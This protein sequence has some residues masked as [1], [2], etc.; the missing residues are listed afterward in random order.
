MITALL[1][2]LVQI[3]GGGTPDKA[4]SAYWGGSIPWVTVKD[5][6]S[7]Q[8]DDAIDSITPL[9]VASSATHVVAAG[10]LLVPTRMAVGKAAI[11]T[12]DV[13]INQDIKALL[14]GPKIDVRYLLHVLVS[15]ASELQRQATGATVK[16]ITLDVLRRLEIPLP[17]LDEQRRLA[18]VLDQANDL[19]RKRRAM[20]ERLIAAPN[21]KFQEMFGDA[22]GSN[23]RY[24]AVELNTVISPTRPITYGILKPGPDVRAG[25][26]YVRVVDIKNGTVLT[27]QLRRTSPEIAS[28]YRRSVL[29]AGDLLM[30]IRGHVGRMAFVPEE[31][32]GAN[33]TQDT[34]R[35]AIVGANS[36]FVRWALGSP[37]GMRWLK[38]YVRG[39][40]VQGINLGDLRKFPLIMPPRIE[41]D[42]F[43]EFV[44]E[45]EQARAAAEGHLV[46]L[47]ALFASLQHR[48]FRGG[49]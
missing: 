16:G 6:K 31:I 29:Q 46:Q 14:P 19:R 37:L 45:A 22:V 7:T 21:A 44:G 39:I 15:K 2:D 8:I 34:A 42:L 18:T 33:I 9:G 24:P 1:G 38:N 20:I 36:T 27:H 17:P 48:A 43:A 49:L 3:R 23:A 35:L 5:F 41:Q 4:V 28:Q 13:A 26:A 12:V 25:Q 32:S 30:S 10:S 47:D 40:A 11:N